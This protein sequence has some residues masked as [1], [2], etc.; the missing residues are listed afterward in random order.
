MNAKKLL[1]LAAAIVATAAVGQAVSPG[2]DA[3]VAERTRPFGKLC[4]Q[5]EDCG[6]EPPPAA[7]APVEQALSGEEVYSQ[8]CHTC[9]GTGLNDAPK[10]GD[11]EAWASRLAKGMDVLLQNTKQGFNLMPAN[12]LCASCS[13]DEFIAAID[14]MSVTADE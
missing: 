1:C 10:L 14:H 7:P 5:G 9:H 11:A 13:D 6:G 12:G 2:T 8:Y 3:D 4:L